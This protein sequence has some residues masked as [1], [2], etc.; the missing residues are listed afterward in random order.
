MARLT[1]TKDTDGAPQTQR[2]QLQRNAVAEAISKS[3]E[4]LPFCL[5][6]QHHWP[7]DR[8]ALQQQDLAYVW[9]VMGM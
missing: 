9:E 5:S 8:T 1:K 3:L 4:S 6:N 7:I 2:S